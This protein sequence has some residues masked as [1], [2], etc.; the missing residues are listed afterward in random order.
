MDCTDFEACTIIGCTDF[1]ARTIIGNNDKHSLLKLIGQVP[2]IT[3]MEHSFSPWVPLEIYNIDSKEE[4]NIN[5]NDQFEDIES[6]IT[7]GNKKYYEQYFNKI[8]NKNFTFNINNEMK[9]RLEEIDQ[10]Y[11]YEVTDCIKILPINFE[12]ARGRARCQQLKNL[13]PVQRKMEEKVRLIKNKYCAK[14]TRVKKNENLLK[15]EKKINFLK[16]KINKYEYL[17]EKILS[18]IK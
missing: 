5:Q 10:D 13:T 2:M 6:D 14:K 12:P 18:K 15:L 17:F 8:K 7:L 11:E 9:N 16:K 1:E 3:N 4:L